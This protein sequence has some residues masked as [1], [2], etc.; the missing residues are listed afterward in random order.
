MGE[1]FRD[2]VLKDVFGRD[3]PQRDDKQNVCYHIYIPQPHFPNIPQ[4]RN[5]K[6]HLKLADSK[7]LN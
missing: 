1:V 6:V 5:I 4:P 3:S 2:V 7:F